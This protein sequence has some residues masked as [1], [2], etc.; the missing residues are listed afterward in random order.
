MSKEIDELLNNE[1]K[2]K[3][4]AKEAIDMMDKNKDG[5][6]D[7]KELKGFLDNVCKEAGIE[8]NFSESEV[9]GVFDSIDKDKSGK[10]TVDEMAELLKQILKDVAK[11]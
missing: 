2:L 9:K 11:A 4:K 5:S 3:A 6:I 1:T 10:I 8:G 7:I